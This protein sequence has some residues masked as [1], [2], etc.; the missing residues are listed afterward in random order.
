M[1]YPSE[2]L[3]KKIVRDNGVNKNRTTVVAIR[4]WSSKKNKRGE[5]DDVMAVCSPHGVTFYRYLLLTIVLPL[6]RYDFS[7]RM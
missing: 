7:I 5:Y 2:E 6:S 3:I 4:G 1:N